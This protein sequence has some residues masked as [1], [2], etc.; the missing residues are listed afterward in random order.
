M[1]RIKKILCPVDFSDMS[2]ETLEIAIQLAEKYAAAF[3]IIYV[4]PRPNFYDWTLTGMSNI[5]LDD[6]FE[7]TKK[8]VDKKIKAMV[9]MIRAD[10][11][12]VEVTS[13]ISD[14]MD[15]AEG[16]LESAKNTKAELI[17]MG[18][19]GRK[20]LN[21]ILMGSVAESVLRHAPCGVMIYKSKPTKKK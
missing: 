4:L 2:E 15:P 14:K 17:I 21:R 1:K 5:V 3:H 13:E 18:S 20:G 9:E 10:H 16:I 12:F 11:P 7:K 6:W 8:D 19:H